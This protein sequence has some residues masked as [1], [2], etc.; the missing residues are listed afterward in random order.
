MLAGSAIIGGLAEL[1][2][3]PAVLGAV[4]ASGP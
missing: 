4:V 3:L 2:G 1:I